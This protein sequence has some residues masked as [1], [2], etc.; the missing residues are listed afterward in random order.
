[1]KDYKS[2]DDR[3]YH[4]YKAYKDANGK[5]FKKVAGKMRIH[6]GGKVHMTDMTS[7]EFKTFHVKEGDAAYLGPVPGH[8][9]KVTIGPYGELYIRLDNYFDPTTIT[10]ILHHDG[11]QVYIDDHSDGKSAVEAYKIEGMEG[12][13]LIMNGEQFVAILK[14]DKKAPSPAPMDH[15]YPKNTKDKN[16]FLKPSV[17]KAEHIAKKVDKIAKVVKKATK[18]VKK[19]A[20]NSKAGRAKMNGESK[21]DKYTRCNA[22]ASGAEVL[23]C[24]GAGKLALLM[25]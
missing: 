9:D 16:G 22:L 11:H 14:E 6:T 5:Q 7:N 17:V 4:L 19:V 13:Q 25:I 12:G 3:L 20:K 21:D 15:H 23:Q 1:M 10:S 24:L 8:F 2:D 18:K